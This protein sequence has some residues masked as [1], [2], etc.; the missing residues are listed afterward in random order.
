MKKMTTFIK[1]RW[2][3]ILSVVVILVALPV[4]WVMSGKLNT[5]LKDGQEQKANALYTQLDGLKV[6]YE[7]LAPVEGMKLGGGQ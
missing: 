6:N 7:L 2:P 3:L 5:K 4:A 1:K